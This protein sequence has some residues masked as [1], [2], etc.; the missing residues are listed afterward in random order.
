MLVKSILLT[1]PYAHICQF[2]DSYISS[3]D[4]ER[5]GLSFMPAVFGTFVGNSL[6]R[7]VPRQ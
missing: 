3:A 7:I 4:L 2:M 5:F 6:D 1:N